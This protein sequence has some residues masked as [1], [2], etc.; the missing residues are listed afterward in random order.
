MSANTDPILGRAMRLFQPNIAVPLGVAAAYYLGAEVAFAIGTLTHQ[1]APFWPPNV[2]LLCAF[3]TV[4]R[5]RWPLIVLFC[6]PVHILA[7]LGAQMPSPQVLMAFCSNVAVALLNA[8]LLHRLFPRRDWLSGVHNTVAYLVAAVM[9]IPALVACLAAFEPMLGD[10]GFGDYGQFW[11]RWYLSNAMGNLT[12]TPV[13]LAWAPDFRRL[14][15]PDQRRVAEIAA[16]TLGLAISCGLAFVSVAGIGEN[17]IPAF[18]YLPIPFLLATAIRFGVKGATG[19]I[20]I[21]AVALIV[22]AMDATG[23]SAGWSVLSMQLFLAETAIP[24]ILLGAFVEE[25]RRRNRDLAAARGGMG[26]L[27]DTPRN[28]KIDTEDELARHILLAATD[29]SPGQRRAALLV[30]LTVLAACIVTLPFAKIAGPPIPGFT[31]I[32]QAW[33]AVTDLMTASLL[34]GQFWVLPTRRLNVLAG[35][36]FFAAFATIPYAL[37]FPGGF[38]E[39]G[40]LTGGPLSTPWIF[41]AWYAAL[42][43]VVIAYSSSA[44][45]GTKYSRG[46]G[47][48]GILLPVVAAVGATVA[49]TTLVTAGYDWLPVVW[50]VDGYT[51]A[52]RLAIDGAMGLALLALLMLARRRPYSVL[53]TWLMVVMF[54]WVGAIVIGGGVLGT[55]RY[56]I[57]NDV[58]RAL[59][60]LASNFVLLVLLSQMIALH[61]KTIRDREQRLVA[62]LDGRYRAEVAARASETLLQSS[63]NAL[64][65]PFAI[66]DGT[67][68]ILTVNASWSKIAELIIPSGERYFI[69]DNYLNG[70]EA[71]RPHQ[72]EIA[73]GLRRVIDGELGEFRFEY[74]SDFIGG[75]WFQMRAT[76]F[77][78]DGELRV[79]VAHEDITEIKRS[80]SALRQL[81]ARLMLVGDE[82]RRQIAR[83][84][85]D[86]TAQNLLAATLGIGQ[87]LRRWPRLPRTARAALEESHELIDQSQ[88]EIRTVA[89][90]LHPPMLDA[91]GLPAALRWLGNGFSKRAEIRVELDGVEDVGRLPA[92][93]EAALFRIAQ[94]ALTNVHRHSG[95][96]RAR[97]SLKATT[98]ESEPQIVLAIED[99]GCGIL[100]ESAVESGNAPHGHLPGVGLTGM[101]ERLRPLGGTLKIDTSPRG[102]RV[103]ATIPCATRDAGPAAESR[104]NTFSY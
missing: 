33:M 52:A 91:A 3:L 59:Y 38:S 93:V 53:D 28:R 43:L 31:L 74:K 81:S 85:H 7:E 19:A 25:L 97:V 32:Q 78:V 89:Y 56:D 62:A 49:L 15:A 96:A 84:L 34:L 57:G 95:S 20:L 1:F 90:L 101:R 24:V 51:P 69:G 35:G 87:V 100:A 92:G 82:N 103:F 11:W 64:N 45:R 104:E 77:V 48:I 30:G 2:I 22:R 21:F 68:M 46:D 94:E 42:P 65:A 47:R 67:G 76:R 6:L 80:E 86:S 13:F 10:G 99:D 72:R 36:Y 44:D 50:A 4:P 63:L 83:D 26:N 5:R 40:L 79:V 37:S 61:A 102:T 17:T 23:T 66:L 60:M 70:S 12:L 73:A 55:R 9:L 18:I 54:T 16:L 88:R 14:R 71:G 39:K 29:A 41:L 75:H 8:V 58:S 27:P 98:A